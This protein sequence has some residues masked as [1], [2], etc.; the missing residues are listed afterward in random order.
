[1]YFG[2]IYVGEYYRQER[3]FYDTTSQWVTINNMGIPN[4]EMISNYDI[5][6]SDSAVQQFTKNGDSMEY[7]VD[8]GRF[9]LHGKEWKDKMCLDQNRNNRMDDTGRLCVR[10]MPFLDVD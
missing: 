5:R 4:A 6:E 3:V 7:S 8:F 2:P 1:M 10:N 9:N